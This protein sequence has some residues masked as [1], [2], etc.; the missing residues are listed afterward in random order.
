MTDDSDSRTTSESLSVSARLHNSTASSRHGS[1]SSSNSDVP[2]QEKGLTNDV[3]DFGNENS[4]PSSLCSRILTKMEELDELE[5][6]LKSLKGNIK[7]VIKEDQMLVS[8]CSV[9]QSNNCDL[10]ESAQAQRAYLAY[11]DYLS[12]ENELEEAL[13]EYEESMVKRSTANG[14]ESGELFPKVHAVAVDRLRRKLSSADV[15][16]R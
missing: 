1:S 6:K 7:L 11:L 10:A 8:L 2:N 3:L 12:T 14:E 4:Q 5:E 15:Q 13:C 16:L 9:Q